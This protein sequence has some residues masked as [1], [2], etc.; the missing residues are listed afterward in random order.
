MTSPAP[1]KRSRARAPFRVQLMIDPTLVYFREA[2]LGVRQYGFETGRLEI[3]DRWLAHERFNLAELVRRDRV[4]GIV[5]AVHWPGLEAKLAR[6]NIPVVN[7]SNTMP[8]PRLVVVTQDDHAVGRLAHEHLALS[9]CRQFAFWGQSRA[10]YSMERLEGFRAGMAA[11]GGT[12]DVIHTQPRYGPQEY[13]R[14]LR[15]L[16]G[17]KRPL[18]VF[19][20]LDAFAVLVLR[21]A[22]ELGWRVPEDI[23]VLGAGDDDFLV[24]YE[25]IPLSSVK[26]PARRIGYEAGAEIDRLIAGTPAGTRRVRLPPPGLTARQSSDTIFVRDEAVVKA[27]RYIRTHATSSPYIGDIAR[28][29]GIARTTLQQRFR[30]VVGRTLLDEIQRVRIEHAKQFLRTG[31]LSLEAISERCGFANSQRFSLLFRQHTGLPPGRFRR[32][33]RQG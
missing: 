1:A 24:S 25:Q 13:H 7:V 9:G 3:I 17:M 22:R 30:A 18:G 15:W 19:A 27:I 21:A 20:V 14:I 12:L 6:L 31:D 10:L 2:T 26:L 11:S 33:S 8:L 32:S 23:A 16:A 28:A 29:A 4:Q 5:A